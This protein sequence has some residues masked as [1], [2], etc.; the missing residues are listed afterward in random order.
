MHGNYQYLSELR[1]QARYYI[2]EGMGQQLFDLNE[3]NQLIPCSGRGIFSYIG[4]GSGKRSVKHIQNVQRAC[5]EVAHKSDSFAIQLGLHDRMAEHLK[6]LNWEA[7]TFKELA[8]ELDAMLSSESAQLLKAHEVLLAMIDRCR[9]FAEERPDSSEIEKEFGLFEEA[10]ASAFDDFSLSQNLDTEAALKQFYHL[11]TPVVN[12]A[13]NIM[14]GHSEHKDKETLDFLADE[15]ETSFQQ[16]INVLQEKEERL[17]DYTPPKL[18]PFPTIRSLECTQIPVIE[19]QEPAITLRS[20]KQQLQ[21]FIQGEITENLS[22]YCQQLFQDSLD[23]ISQHA[24]ID[25]QLYEINQLILWLTQSM[26]QVY[27]SAGYLYQNLEVECLFPLTEHQVKLEKKKR[28]ATVLLTSHNTIDTTPPQK[29][30]ISDKELYKTGLVA[31]EQEYEELCDIMGTPFM[32]WPGIKPRLEAFRQLQHFNPGISNQH[33]KVLMDFM[34]PDQ[35]EH[36]VSSMCHFSEVA[37]Y[38]GILGAVEK[39]IQ[40]I[41]G[42]QQVSPAVLNVLPYISMDGLS[43]PYLLS[44]LSALNMLVKSLGEDCLNLSEMATAINH[45]LLPPPT[46][47]QINN[48]WK[49]PE[50]LAH[51]S[52]CLI[53]MIRNSLSE[54]K[55]KRK[56]YNT[57]SVIQALEARFQMSPTPIPENDDCLF[58]AAGYAMGEPI[59]KVRERCHLVAKDILNMKAGL[60]EPDLH[61]DY[62]GRITHAANNMSPQELEN[63]RE[64]V[65]NNRLLTPAFESNVPQEHRASSDDLAL[66][67]LAYNCPI[68]P[69]YPESGLEDTSGF[70]PNGTEQRNTESYGSVKYLTKATGKLPL[71]LICHDHHWEPLIN[72]VR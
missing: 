41:A 33:F 59:R 57:E 27:H 69:I 16:V 56:I 61:T 25:E 36:W 17:L 10:I 39:A 65:I 48:A 30:S 12:Q 52:Q 28:E 58:A 49:N 43:T 7:M 4:W 68:V 62:A 3:Q 54:G 26:E 40:I 72:V 45:H 47:E 37:N 50:A 23:Y 34:E 11:L 5:I 9:E 15:I 71:I 51:A 53:K 64:K 24:S 18:T 22:D 35:I 19:A 20:V 46:I 2:S 63:L 8:D 60:F 6:A 21:V 67:A 14:G 29:P 32:H 70:F 42:Q 1:D 38:N 44:Q 13:F 55:Y 66:L 31:N